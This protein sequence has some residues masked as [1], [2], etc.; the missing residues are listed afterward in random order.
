M[1][2]EWPGCFPSQAAAVEAHFGLMPEVVRLHSKTE[3]MLNRLRSRGIPIGVVT[4]G[5]SETQWGKLRNTGVD[6][7]VTACV[8][9]EDFGARK[10]DPAIFRHALGLLGAEAESTLFVGDNVEEDI[11]GASRMNMRTAWMCLGRS[12]DS[13]LPHPAYILDAAWEVEGIVLQNPVP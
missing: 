9:S 10:P 8:V 1:L 5:G 7:L 4:N 6:A 13:G 12:W 2:D 3:A 11:L